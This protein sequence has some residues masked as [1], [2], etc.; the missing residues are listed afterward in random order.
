MGLE[1]TFYL[2]DQWLIALGMVAVLTV[3][4]EMGFQA[5][6]RK[7]N[8][9]ESFRSLMS[10]IGA[11]T[12]GLLGL[13]LGFTLAMAIDRWDERHDIIVDES[14]AIGTLWLRAGFFQE[15][16]RDDL[17]EALREYT[18][19]RITLGGSRDDLEAWRAARKKSESLH[20]RI[21]SAVERAGQPEVSPAK[22]S[23]LIIAAN[24]LID[25]HELRLASIENFLPASL[26]LLL[27]GVAAVAIG[28][29]A[30]SFGAVAH[31][32]RTA[33]LVLALLIGSVLLLIMDMNRPQRG[34]FEVGVA[35]ME[36]MR[37]SIETPSMP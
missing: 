12:L 16:T 6:S 32:G 11:A 15:P 20:V 2:I 36:R 33:M 27:L 22:L 3:A 5:G 4:S 34:M 26:L 29:L 31:R 14:N 23:S 9:P 18:D 25:I 7:Q 21:W 37:D 35:T 24:E 30:W 28:F 19:S 10:G 1:L 13:L 8:V 17:R